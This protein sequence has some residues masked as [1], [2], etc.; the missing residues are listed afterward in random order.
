MRKGG[1]RS[2][3]SLT[4]NYLKNQEHFADLCNYVIFDGR[5]VIQSS[6]L[7]EMNTE[8]LVIP[9]DDDFLTFPQHR[10]R[11]LMNGCVAGQT[12]KAVFLIVG[13]ENQTGVHYAMAA[14]NMLY[15]AINYGAQVSKIA[16][17]HKTKKDTKG[18]EFLS[19]FLKTDRLIPVITITVYWGTDEW[20]GARS[21]H[22]MFG[23]IPEEIRRLAA[24]YKLNLLVPCEIT[25]FSKFRT[26]FGFVME[27]LKNALD[28]N[29]MQTFISKYDEIPAE[30]GILINALTNAKLEI[31]QEQG[32]AK[33][34]KAWEDQREEGKLEGI[35][36]TL[37]ALELIAQGCATVDELI[38]QGI[39]REVAEQVV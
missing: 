6:E 32:V 30:T 12:E 14:R 3:D 19:G 21:V 23:D 28:R 26:D 24:D 9:Y 18:D 22:D 1:M 20:D 29:Q 16:R 4:K 37:R 11:D 15:D 2:R 38:E 35:K 39:S 8:E 36:E 7:Q 34:C 25:D 10:I 5:Q 13:V 33:V 17:Q 27:F 31:N